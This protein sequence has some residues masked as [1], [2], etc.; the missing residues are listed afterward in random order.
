MRYLRGKK[1]ECVN[2]TLFRNVL[3]YKTRRR[4]ADGGMKESILA[5]DVFK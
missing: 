2:I 3:R 4:L 5:K 1:K